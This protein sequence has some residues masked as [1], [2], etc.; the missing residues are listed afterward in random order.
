MD[1]KYYILG[2]LA[3]IILTVIMA[4][5]YIIC[6]R[7]T[8]VIDIKN[9][10]IL[11]SSDNA[12]LYIDRIDIKDNV[13]V[14]FAAAKDGNI[15]Y[16]YDNWVLGEGND[17]YKNR[18]LL[19]VD[20]KSET[21]RVLPSYPY[22][23]TPETDLSNHQCYEYS[24]IKAYIDNSYSGSD[25]DLLIAVLFKDRDGNKYICYQKGSIHAD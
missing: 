8:Y 20:P 3:C 5:T 22:L 17:V 18:S 24:G 2:T 9:I 11:S 14:I 12:Y 10:P 15:V 23:F 16:S 4:V 7:H 19:L 13:K 21:A 25:R 6:A 1:K